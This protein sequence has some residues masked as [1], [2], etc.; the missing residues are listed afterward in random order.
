MAKAAVQ[1]LF[2]MYPG[3]YMVVQVATNIGAVKFWHSVYDKCNIS[4]CDKEVEFD[5]QNGLQQKF[6]AGETL[7]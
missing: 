6:T 2:N 3:K 7:L 5:G 4:Y 1:K